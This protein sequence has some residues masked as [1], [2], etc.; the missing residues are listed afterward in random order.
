MRDVR[1]LEAIRLIMARLRQRPELR[2]VK[3]SELEADLNTGDILLLPGETVLC[4]SAMANL[5]GPRPD[6]S[7]FICSFFTRAKCPALMQVVKGGNCS[8]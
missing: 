5:G 1:S 2:S 7:A 6:L 3:L 4:I 8:I